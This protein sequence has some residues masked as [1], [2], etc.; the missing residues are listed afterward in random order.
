MAAGLNHCQNHFEG[1][2]AEV[3]ELHARAQIRRPNGDATLKAALW[4]KPTTGTSRPQLLASLHLLY[5]RTGIA[6]L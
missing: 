3:Q 6:A 2:F 5:L 4:P 1:L